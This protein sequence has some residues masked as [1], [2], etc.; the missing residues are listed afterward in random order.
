MKPFFLDVDTQNDFVLPAGSLYAL[1]AELI[2]PAIAALNRFAMARGYQLVSTACLHPEN[3]SEFRLWPPH[4]VTGTV[5]QLKP[6]A[7]LVGQQLFQKQY[8]DVF[9][10]PRFEQMVAASDA[11][12]FVV[13]GVV[14]EVCVRFAAE[15]LLR[16]GRPVTVVSDAVQALHEQDGAAFLRQFRSAGGLVRVSAEL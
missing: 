13:Y 2:I 10:D 6:S 3:D 15:G 7:T 12:E 14:T 1:G 16:F 11:S 4:C 9:R 8:T 5:G